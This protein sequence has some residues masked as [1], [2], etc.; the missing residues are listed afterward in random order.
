[1]T[2]PTPQ[3]LRVEQL[4]WQDPLL[5]ELP[6]PQGTMRLTRSLTSGLTLGANPGEF[7]GVGDRGPNLKPKAALKHY[8]LTALAAYAETDG[9][10]VMPLPETGP[11]LARFR[12][13]GDAVKLIEVAA[14]RTPDGTPLSGL[15]LPVPSQESEP[16]LTLDGT[17]LGCHADGADTEGIARRADGK[18]WIAEEYGPSLLLAGADGLIE[19]R[20]VPVG[21]AQYFAGSAIPIIE[22]LPALAVARKLNRGFEALALSPDGKVLFTAFQS[23]LSHPDRSAHEHSDLARIW[24]LDAENGT[25]LAEFAYPLGPRKGFRRDLAEGSVK[26]DD[27]KISELTMLDDGS[28]LVLERVTLSTHIY[29]VQPRSGLALAPEW[30]DPARRPTLEQVGSAG[31]AA[32]DKQ[33]VFSTDDH[34][35]ICGDLEGMIMLAPGTMLLA[36]DSD[37]G[38]EG[39]ETEFW[40][41]TFAEPLVAA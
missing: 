8:G 41:I 23:P 26:R 19:A 3:V 7:W 16:A 34:P 35:E 10:K 5:A 20:H 17:P 33:L 29:R 38:T 36:N 27:I 12:I 32:L 37:Y 18:L 9:A 13:D 31:V 40:R 11:A 25:L 1:M 22:S 24:A 39:V 28:L 21:T 14:L 6:M 2:G 4:A 15:P 30:R